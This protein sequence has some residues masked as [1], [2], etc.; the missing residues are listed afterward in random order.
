MRCGSCG[1]VIESEDDVAWVRGTA[2]CPECMAKG[3]ATQRAFFTVWLVLLILILGVPLL[4]CLGGVV[5]YWLF[6]MK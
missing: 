3:R 1:G 6:P 5:F 2:I 4:L